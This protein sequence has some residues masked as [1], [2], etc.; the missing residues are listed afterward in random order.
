[1][2]SAG[3]RQEH[4]V[5][6]E[7]CQSKVEILVDYSYRHISSLMTIDDGGTRNV[8]GRVREIDKDS[9]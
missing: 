5:G 7:Y 6:N 8:R 3:G 4:I 2:W 1:M 9:Y